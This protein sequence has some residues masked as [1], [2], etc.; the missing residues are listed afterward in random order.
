MGRCG[1]AP[2]RDTRKSVLSVPAV[3]HYVFATA[4]PSR[5]SR[6]FSRWVLHLDGQAG[7]RWQGLDGQ[8][9]RLAGQPGEVSPG[10]PRSLATRSD[11]G[12]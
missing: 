8:G 11:L 7:L 9:E 1:G 10:I 2:T 5:P 4:V 6:S 3:T 12:G